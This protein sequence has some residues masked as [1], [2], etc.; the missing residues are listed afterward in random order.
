MTF[1]AR[2]GRPS[3]GPDSKPS[4]R[5][6]SRSPFCVVH[7]N[8]SPPRGSKPQSEHKRARS[9]TSVSRRRASTVFR[10]TSRQ[11]SRESSKLKD[12]SSGSALSFELS[13]RAVYGWPMNQAARVASVLLGVAGLA[14][15][16]RENQTPA[17]TVT[18]TAET[19]ARHTHTNRLAQQK[20]P[21]LLQHAH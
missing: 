21:Y 3:A 20:S 11:A 10:T 8:N 18:T 5:R 14:G 16:K 6:M 19:F 17:K 13:P 12:Q 7:Q 4:A 9:E 2:T 1:S 15:C